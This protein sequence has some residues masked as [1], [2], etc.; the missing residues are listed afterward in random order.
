MDQ[1]TCL[2]NTWDN[3]LLADG[4]KFLKKL[5]ENLTSENVCMCTLLCLCVCVYV[6]TQ[7]C[8]NFLGVSKGA[9]TDTL[10]T[11]LFMAAQLGVA[12]AAQLGVAWPRKEPNCSHYLLITWTCS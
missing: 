8:F 10:R 3:K 7:N 12:Q 1:L 2:K 5:L 9:L 6:H 11:D 4:L